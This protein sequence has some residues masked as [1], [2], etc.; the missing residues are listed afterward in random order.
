[1]HGRGHRRIIFNNDNNYVSL[2]KCLTECDKGK[3]MEVVNVEAGQHA[4]RR[5]AHLG[6]F[7]GTIIIKKK[8]APWNGPV[9][10]IVR[11]TSLVLGRGLAAKV[12]VKCNDHC[13]N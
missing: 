12:M 4:K 5:L 3:E 7:P 10:I 2:L 8:S 1:M 9:E 13:V 6:V 11:G